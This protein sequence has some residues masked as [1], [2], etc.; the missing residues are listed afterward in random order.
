MKADEKLILFV[1]KEFGISPDQILDAE[2]VDG[3]IKVTMVK[4]IEFITIET[5][6][7]DGVKIDG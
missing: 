1:A 6:V 7:T 3:I 5:T 2:I 4:S